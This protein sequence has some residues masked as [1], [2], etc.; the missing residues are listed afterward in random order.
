MINALLMSR[1]Q[2]LFEGFTEVSEREALV[3][4]LTHFKNGPT[5]GQV[6][7][8]STL[9]EA[10]AHCV[11]CLEFEDSIYR[12]VHTELTHA[13]SWH[14]SLAGEAY[15][16]G[17]YDKYKH[18]DAELKQQRIRDQRKSMEDGEV[19]IESAKTVI[20]EINEITRLAADNFE[21]A[22]ARL[23]AEAAAE[24]QRHDEQIKLDRAEDL[25]NQQ[26]AVYVPPLAEDAPDEQ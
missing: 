6:G 1:Y 16:N 5:A 13:F 12:K 9:L 17:V 22:K 11:N 24:Q 15:W 14:L 21:Q 3:G 8:D 20:S 2:F 7:A 19:E 4:E 18:A 25:K 23:I 10:Y 26:A